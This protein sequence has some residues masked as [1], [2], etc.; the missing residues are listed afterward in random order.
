MRK[1]FVAT[2]SVILMATSLLTAATISAPAATVKLTK[3]VPIS[4]AEL[5][6]E[7]RQYQESAKA[8]GGDPTTVDPL[9]VLNLLINNE[10]F[11]IGR[12]SCRE[13]V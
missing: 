4:M 2:V 5:E 9:Q 13:R 6:S 3:T 1:G 12:A 7:V 10:L 8:S 11:Q